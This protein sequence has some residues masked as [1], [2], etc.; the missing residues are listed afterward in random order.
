MYVIIMIVMKFK[1][2]LFS[3]KN[4]QLEYSIINVREIWKMFFKFYGYYWCCFLQGNRYV[5]IGVC[6]YR[7]INIQIL[8]F[9]F[10]G[11]QV[12][13]GIYLFVVFSYFVFKNV[14]IILFYCLY[15]G[16]NWNLFL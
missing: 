11:I 15:F 8:M 3:Y 14:I 6:F 9:V 4:Y 16:E 13:Y 7:D 10:I 2:L 12:D 5:D 1:Y